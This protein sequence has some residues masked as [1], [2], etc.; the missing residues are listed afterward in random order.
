MRWAKVCGQKQPPSKS[1][2][3]VKLFRNSGFVPTPRKREPPKLLSCPKVRFKH[4]CGASGCVFKTV[5]INIQAAEVLTSD[6]SSEIV[7]SI[8]VLTFL[9]HHNMVKNNKAIPL[10]LQTK[11]NATKTKQQTTK[12]A[13]GENCNKDINQNAH[14]MPHTNRDT[15]IHRD[16]TATFALWFEVALVCHKFWGSKPDLVKKLHFRECCGV[17]SKVADN[18]SSCSSVRSFLLREKS[19]FHPKKSV[20]FSLGIAVGASNFSRTKAIWIAILRIIILSNQF[21][22]KNQNASDFV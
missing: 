16:K 11:Q 8:D 3:H 20:M 6:A 14:T 15:E 5:P 21:A 2:E 17:V 22:P 9:S 10:S 18:T 7:W 12:E 19:D 13:I 4:V 1:G